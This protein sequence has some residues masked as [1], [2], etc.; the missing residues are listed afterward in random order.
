VEDLQG[1][2]TL[3]LEVGGEKDG[4]EAPSSQLALDA[5]PVG[6]RLLQSFEE[7]GHPNRLRRSDCQLQYGAWSGAAR[8][9][10]ARLPP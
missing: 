5:I 2:F 10:V 3:M 4:C 1:D 8:P 6:Q 7:V 9:Q